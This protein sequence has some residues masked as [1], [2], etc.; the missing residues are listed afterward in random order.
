M[1]DEALTKF[2]IQCRDAV[3]EDFD[4]SAGF[5]A[6]RPHIA[7]YTSLEVLEKIA[8]SDTLWMSHPLL[9]NDH[10]EMRWAMVVGRQRLFASSRLSAVC[11]SPTRLQELLRGFDEAMAT[12]TVFFAP[13]IFVA[14]FSEHDKNDIDGRLSMWRGYGAQGGGVALIFD[15]NKFEAS[16]N[17]ASPFVLH[18]VSYQSTSQREQRIDG[19]LEKLALLIEQASPADEHLWIAGA[20]FLERLKILGLFTK[21][22]GFQEEAEWRLAYLADRDTTGT[23]RDFLSYTIGPRGAHPK[24]KL[25]IAPHAGIADTALSLEKITSRIIHGPTAASPLS[26]HAVRNMLHTAGKQELATRLDSSSIP[27]RN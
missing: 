11:G 20:H 6:R 14:C 27:F 22:I 5:P 17:Q 24:M 9:M 13:N 23:F 8:H 18:P 2:D 21:H 7:H 12:F 4:L 19:V 3:W 26:L 25:K 15:T 1:A 10:E 16:T